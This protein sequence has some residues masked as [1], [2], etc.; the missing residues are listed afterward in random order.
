MAVDVL[1]QRPM[2]VLFSHVDGDSEQLG[3]DVLTHLD[4]RPI[5]DAVQDGY[6]RAYSVAS[7]APPSVV[8]EHPPSVFCAIAARA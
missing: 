8:F 4:L 5:K 6:G 1:R 7:P 3:D 2:T